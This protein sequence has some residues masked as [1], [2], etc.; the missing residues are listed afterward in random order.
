MVEDPFWGIDSLTQDVTNFDVHAGDPIT[1]WW[2]MQ[3]FVFVW[4]ERERARKMRFKIES[5]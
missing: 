1:L 5:K 4:G 3:V 2:R